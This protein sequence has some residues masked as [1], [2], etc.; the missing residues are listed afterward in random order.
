VYLVDTNIISVAA[1]TKTRPGSVLAAWMEQ[2]TDRLYLSAVTVTEIED[3][4]AKAERTGAHQ[5]AA[6]LE[7][8]FETVLH[9]YSDRILA[10]D[11][12]AARVAGR[13]SDLARGRGFSPGFADLAIAATAR[14]HGMVVL[15]RNLR[16]FVSIDVRAVD[17]IGN[18]Q[19]LR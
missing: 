16:H 3:G 17:P 1:P 2:N 8:W 5:K 19:A 11:L 14:R 4:I 6:M 9:L 13:L 10:F 12:D 7:A 18:P 15:T